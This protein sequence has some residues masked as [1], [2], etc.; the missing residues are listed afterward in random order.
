MRCIYVL[1]PANADSM[2]AVELTL[3]IRGQY[4][5]LTACTHRESNTDDVHSTIDASI[6][7]MLDTCAATRAEQLATKAHPVRL[8]A[9]G[10]PLQSG[11]GRALA[12]TYLAQSFSHKQPCQKQCN[13]NSRAHS[14]HSCSGF[15]EQARYVEPVPLCLCLPGHFLARPLREAPGQLHK[16]VRSRFGMPSWQ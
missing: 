12:C 11:N 2:Q 16:H 14:S 10:S 1:R 13:E 8:C 3:L 7:A 5:F 9:R 6:Q 4:I 15:P